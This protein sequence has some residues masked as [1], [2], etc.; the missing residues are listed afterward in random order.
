MSDWILLLL[1]VR[2]NSYASHPIR[3]EKNDGNHKTSI[4]L[5]QL[6]SCLYSFI[7]PVQSCQLTSF[8]S[9]TCFCC[10]IVQNSEVKWDICRNGM[11]AGEW[12]LVDCSATFSPTH[13]PKHDLKLD[14]K[15]FPI[16][17]SVCCSLERNAIKRISWLV[18]VW[19][20][21]YTT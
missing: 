12:F 17:T 5:E 13:F 2:G 9:V 11:G 20:D 3:T 18:C 15:S 14:R 6:I 19:T 16:Q 8:R 7:A 1:D 21:A 10:Y 4:P